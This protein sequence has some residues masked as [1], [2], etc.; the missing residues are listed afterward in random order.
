LTFNII[1]VPILN[2]SELPET[3]TQREISEV[4]SWHGVDET[5][6]LIPGSDLIN[7]PI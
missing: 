6:F 3:I 4:L 7:M 1:E 5:L 2:C